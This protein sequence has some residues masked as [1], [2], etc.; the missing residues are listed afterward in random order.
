MR[1][2]ESEDWMKQVKK[3]KKRTVWKGDDRRK[4]RREREA[5]GS[6]RSKGQVEGSERGKGEDGGVFRLLLSVFSPGMKQ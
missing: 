3:E 4:G 1:M 6:E 2:E 5:Y